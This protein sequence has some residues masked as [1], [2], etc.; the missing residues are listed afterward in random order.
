MKSNKKK[1]FDFIVD[2]TQGF[3]ALEEETPKFDTQF[4]SSQ[5]NMQRSNVSTILNQ[6]V[7][8]GKIEKTNGRP[9]LYCL[10]KD[11][12]IQIDTQDFSSLIG[13]ETSLREAIQYTKAA[14][15]Y[16]MSIPKI[17]Y[18]GEKGVGVETIVN[19]SYQFACSSK[20]LKSKAPFIKVDCSY[21]NE[22]QLV[23]TFLSVDNIFISANQGLLFIKNA[24]VLSNKLVS[25]IMHY[26]SAS[27]TLSLILIVHVNDEMKEISPLKDYFNFIVKLPSLEHRSLD[28]RYQFIE[29]FMQ[30]ESIRLDKK[31]EVNYGLMQCL[32]LYPCLDNLFE[33][34]K[35]IQF[36]IANA[37]IRTKKSHKVVIEMS[38]LPSKVR[39]GLLYM[40]EN[41]IE[42]ERVLGRNCNFTFD[43]DKTLKARSYDSHSDIYQKLDH[44]QKLFGKSINNYESDEFVFANIEEELTEYLEQLT[45]D[46]TEEKINEI[47]SDKLMTLVKEFIHIA[48]IK[49]NRLYSNN[50]FYGM[51][52]HLNN[53]LIRKNT[54]QRITNQ[55]IMEIMDTYDEEYLF[56][57]K[58]IKQIQNEFNVRFS[59][60]ESIFITLFLTLNENN[61]TKKNEVITL[62]A[63]HGEQTA[64]SIVDVVKRLVPV[65]NLESFNLSL[66]KD[67]EISYDLLK[68]K[69]IDINTGKGVLVLYDMGSIQMMLNSIKDETNIDIISI[70]IPIPLLAMN[71]CQYSEEGK[72]LEDIYNHL[73]HEYVEHSYLRNDN[74]DTVIALSTVNE[75]NSDSI[76]RYL[77]TLEDYSDYRIL[78][79]NISD[80]QHLINKINEIQIKGKIIGI[81]GTYNPD[82]FNIKFIDYSHIP[83][84]HT[85]RELF[86]DRKENF[87]VLEYLTEQFEI[88]TYDDLQKTLIPFINQLEVI[89]KKKLNDD[90][91]IGMLIHMGCLIDRLKKKR[92]SNISFTIGETKKRF[93]REIEEVRYILVSL[94][95]YY[96]ISFSEGDVVT[97]VETIMN[98]R[99]RNEI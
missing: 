57:R 83:N 74:K 70:E 38:D 98:T 64:S 26:I 77:Q 13:S 45:E 88:F 43:H 33:L 24:H 42:I 55:K 61:S 37:F 65:K 90:E 28:E 59:L 30:E 6:L 8:E 15:T 29:K 54:K 19:R 35:N 73:I 52:L 89:F 67:I 2:Y 91:K 99:R 14:I 79:F 53:A 87:D 1:V 85:I 10:N 50:I 36:G 95:N 27:N 5:L 66:N 60:D 97:I 72:S 39:R 11:L 25:D 12:K 31:I 49:F 76:K 18:I 94:E 81:V 47:V 69:I 78:S 20:I 68:K 71:S 41:S 22:E 92:G 82:I 62:I 3:N 93:S 63:M 44:K 7:E 40:K 17:L 23:D 84:V 80:K 16:P 34:K 32:M 4:L 96:E 56:S 58:F 21:Y 48:S 75:N 9:V 86:A 51:C 46:I